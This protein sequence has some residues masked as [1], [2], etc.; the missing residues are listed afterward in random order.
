[1][2][3]KKKVRRESRS[4][5]LIRERRLM[6]R[7]ETRRTQ[8]ALKWL[9][10]LA[11]VSRFVGLLLHRDTRTPKLCDF[12]KKE[13]ATWIHC[14]KKSKKQVYLCFGCGGH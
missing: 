8:R 12:C 1:M 2:A 6:R 4:Q 11:P 5:R 3:K 13:R 10:K 9:V 7:R 14:E